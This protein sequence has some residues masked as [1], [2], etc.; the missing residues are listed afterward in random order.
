MDGIYLILVFKECPHYTTWNS[1]DN[2]KRE[3]EK[4][5]KAP[6]GENFKVPV[7]HFA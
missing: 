3:L 2:V 6:I 5:C 1:A 7:L 4:K